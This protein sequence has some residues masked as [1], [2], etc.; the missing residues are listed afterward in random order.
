MTKAAGQSAVGSRQSG[1]SDRGDP[2]RS[3]RD[4]RVWQL[5]IELTVEC[6]EA[7]KAYPP[8]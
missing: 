7:T 4:L 6:Y 8:A 5:A 2:V 1:F 3:Y